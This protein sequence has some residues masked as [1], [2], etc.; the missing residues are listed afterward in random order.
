MN[1]KIIIFDMDGVLF[2]SMKIAQKYFIM[3]HP[4]VTP[5]M[6]KEM[7]TGNYHQESEKYLPLKLNEIEEKKLQGQIT[8]AEAKS[9]A[10]LFDGVKKLLTDLHYLNL[11]LVLNTSA[12]IKTTIPLLEK[13]DIKQ[14]F[15][16]IATAEVS[17]S[18]IEKF[19]LISD[20]YNIKKNDILFITDSLGDVRE[21]EVA[22][23]PTIAVTWGIHNRSYFNLEHNHNLIA[24]VD[25][26]DELRD[27]ILK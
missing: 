19:N 22:G 24:V 10:P 2:D 11:I 6:Y 13:S 4:G 1:K 26:V 25:F 18:K 14:L 9:K 17:K 8:Y 16:F 3:K 5:E 12:F 20:K 7:Y 27:I 21:A 15:D 23:I